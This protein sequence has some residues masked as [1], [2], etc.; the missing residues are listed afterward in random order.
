MALGSQPYDTLLKTARQFDLAVVCMTFLAA[1][2]VSSSSLT[3]PSLAQVLVIRIKVANLFLFGGYLGLC[4][5]VFLACGFY[6]SHRLPR[7]PGRLAEIFAGVTVITS[8]L[9]LL[10]WPLALE[11]ATRSFLCMFWLLTFCTLIVVHEIGRGLSQLARR[12]GRDLRNV[13]IIGEGAEALALAS[14]IR[15]ESSLGYRVL[16]VFDAGEMT[17]NGR[18]IG[19]V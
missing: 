1:L 13:I 3:W 18:T 14:R 9:W 19:D 8:V 15:Q 4:S 16:R 17:E 7:W 6:R 11:F 10:R 2:A 12:R 5:A